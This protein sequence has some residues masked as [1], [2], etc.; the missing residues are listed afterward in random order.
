MGGSIYYQSSEGSELVEMTEELFKKED[1]FQELLANYD[2]LLAGEQIDPDRPRRWLFIAREAGVP[3]QE[4]GGDRW[5]LDH[6][7]LDQDAVPTL[8][9][10]KR[11]TD[12]RIR[13]EVVG[14][15]LDY[16]ANA[17][18]YWPVDEIIARFEATC[19]EED[20][21]PEDI[22]GDFLQGDVEPEDFWEQVR[23]N[24]KAGK[25]RMLF[26]ADK[27]PPELRRIIEFMNEQ[28]DPAEV[29]GVEIKQYASGEQ[30]AY[31][32]RVVGQTAEATSR[33]SSPRGEAWTEERFLQELR[34]EAKEG[35]VAVAID[36][37]RFAT[38]GPNKKPHWGTGKFK[39]TF[40]AGLSLSG[41]RFNLFT[42]DTLGHLSIG[43]GWNTNKPGGSEL[44]ERF[45]TLVNELLSED[46]PRN[47]WETGWPRI[48]LGSLVSDHAEAFK[49]LI[50]Q[51]AAEVTQL[52]EEEIE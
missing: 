23:T 36:L 11:S 31:V 24:L 38:E 29:L 41:T 10:V 30:R 6:L 51:Y 13:R 37:M 17:V 7:F 52:V 27:I 3:D 32:S 18:V 44:S 1:D 49:K 34:S 19:L 8:V 12:T 45:R 9:E 28:M 5:S 39:G 22:L 47:T 42:I 40:S 33:K 14:Q 15:M 26:V 43:L 35:E 46:F 48:S 50:S 21:D 16:A 2:K 25:V 20:K 4:D